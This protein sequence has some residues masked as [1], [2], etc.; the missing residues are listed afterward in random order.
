MTLKFWKIKFKFQVKSPSTSLCLA[1][2][3]LL[4]SLR[5][6][7]QIRKMSLKPGT[8]PKS[9]SP[10][11]LPP[12][13]QKCTPWWAPFP[14]SPVPSRPFHPTYW[15]LAL[16]SPNRSPWWCWRPALWCPPPFECRQATRLWWNRVALHLLPCAFLSMP[17]RNCASDCPC[18]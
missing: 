14:N 4:Q 8:S 16:S 5:L 6:L 12:P 1:L 7:R 13:Q 17:S 2:K 3:H 9:S 15:L 11:L 10:C 18:S